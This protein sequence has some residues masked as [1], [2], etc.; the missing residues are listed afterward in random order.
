MGPKRPC[1]QNNCTREY[2]LEYSVLVFEY[3]L[4]NAISIRTSTQKQVQL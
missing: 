4:R 1:P 2:F 3:F